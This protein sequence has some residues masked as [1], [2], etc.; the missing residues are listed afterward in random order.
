MI[1]VDIEP[2]DIEIVSPAYGETI[3]GRSANITVRATDLKGCG[4]DGSS[5]RVRYGTEGKWTDWLYAGEP[6]DGEEVRITT[7]LNLPFGSV[8]LQFKGSD[9]LR[10]SF[11]SN[12]FIVVMEAPVINKKPV[13]VIASPYN[14]S[15]IEYGDPVFLSAEGSGDDGVGDLSILRFTWISSVDGVIGTVDEK[16]IFLSKGNHT[17][18]LYVDDGAPG[19]NVSVW[20][21]ISI[22]EPDRNGT[23]PNVPIEEDE[24]AWIAFIV[25]LVVTIV[26]VVVLLILM[27]IISKRK[28][29][30]EEVQIWV[31]EGTE[32]DLEYDENEERR[33]RKRGF[34]IE[35]GDL[36]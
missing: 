23:G 20:V 12:E 10:N 16:D 35:D 9:L 4:F 2:P 13:A 7:S 8:S 19:H 25:V 31:T 27:M 28:Q 14:N 3:I 1:G 30:G 34:S 33:A 18:T 6:V 17:I 32:D 15:M 21:N 22:I 36:K 24:S 11:V 26:T 5:L 29:A